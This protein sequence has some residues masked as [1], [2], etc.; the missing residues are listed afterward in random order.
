MKLTFAALASS[1][2]LAP[3]AHAAD[4][5]LS[6]T[7]GGNGGPIIFV[8]SGKTAR[9]D[10]IDGA[11]PFLYRVEETPTQF[12]LTETAETTARW[13]LPGMKESGSIVIDR[14]TG[15]IFFTT[16]IG[17]F[18]PNTSSGQCTLATAKF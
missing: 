4:V 14:I 1:L 8:I 15:E 18:P 10:S 12:K 5:T 16:T 13:A 17:T 6:C 3:A 7:N 2:A 9:A 11:P